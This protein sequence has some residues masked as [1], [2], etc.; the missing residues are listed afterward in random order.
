MSIGIPTDDDPEDRPIDSGLDVPLSRYF[1]RRGWHAPPAM[2][3]YDF[4]DDWRAVLVHESMESAEELQ[5]YPRCI[6]GARRCPPEDC[7][8]V[9][10]YAEF[11]ECGATCPWSGNHYEQLGRSRWIEADGWR[12]GPARRRERFKDVPVVRVHEPGSCSRRCQVDLRT[13]FD[14]IHVEKPVFGGLQQERTGDAPGAPTIAPLLPIGRGARSRVR[15]CETS[16]HIWF[17]AD[18]FQTSSRWTRKVLSA[19]L[20]HTTKS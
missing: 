6:S 18:G 20:L 3:A 15:S 8:G 2:Y 19:R 1:E 9:H 4:G 17:S 16:R 7:G 12:G 11:E 13:R 10:G 5:T 14:S